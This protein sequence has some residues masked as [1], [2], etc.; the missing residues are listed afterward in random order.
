MKRIYTYALYSLY[1]CM[2]LYVVDH[3]LTKISESRLNSNC[4]EFLREA[5]YTE[6]ISMFN[7]AHT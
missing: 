7:D 1:V 4:I 3:R 6:F 2:W 5:E